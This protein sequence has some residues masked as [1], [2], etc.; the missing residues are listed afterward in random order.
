MVIS[1]K[2]SK[3]NFENLEIRQ[4]FDDSIDKIK[5]NQLKWRGN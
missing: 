1:Y 2:S 4:I 5:L 3:K